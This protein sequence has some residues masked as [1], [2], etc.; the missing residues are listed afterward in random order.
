[1]VLEI[2]GILTSAQV[3][4]IL[5]INGPGFEGQEVGVLT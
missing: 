1:M 3:M 2:L 4:L 5:L